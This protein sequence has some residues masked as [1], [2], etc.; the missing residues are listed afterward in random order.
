M[1]HLSIR[2]YNTTVVHNLVNHGIP[3]PLARSLSARGIERYEDI[4]LELKGLIPPNAMMNCEDAGKIL[5]DAIQNNQRIAIVG[6]YDCDG[7]TATA[8]ALIGLKLLGTENTFYLIP[9]R[10]KDGYGLSPTLVQKAKAEGADLLV[11]VDNGISAHVAIKE[12]RKLGLSVLVTDHHLPA[13]TLPEANCIV[14]PN[15]IGDAFPSKNLAGVGV[16]F[17]VLLATRAEM[18]KRGVFDTK[19]QP[20]LLVL[21]DLVALGTIADVVPLDKNN[22][23]LVSKGLE[24]IRSGKMHP[25]IAALLTVSRKN[26]YNL[27]TTDLGFS[28]APRINAAGRLADSQIGVECLKTFDPDIATRHATELDTLNN[29]RRDKEQ[30]G[31]DEA[32]SQMGTIELNEE[33]SIC[34]YRENWH[35]GIVGLIASRIK[36]KSYR[37]T[38]CFA[39]NQNEGNTEELKGSG[40][41]IQGIHLRDLLDYI[42]KRNPGLI[43]KFGG[44]AQAAGLT[45]HKSNLEQFRYELEN[46]VTAFSSQSTFIRSLETDGELTAP[47]FNL[48]LV[49]CIR[50]CV[51]GV[52]FPEPI[53]INRFKV[54]K[55]DLLKGEHL[56]LKLETDGIQL[57]GIWFRRK[58]MLPEVATL[59]YRLKLNE[60][61][62]RRRIDL[63]IE[64]MENE[65]ENWGA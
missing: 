25:G 32:L 38:I 36:D 59:A 56:R 12:A 45:I 13:D 21:I 18:R 9:D 51:W 31:L 43:L 48:H 44:H 40:R 46:A 53:F 50:N 65:Q 17:Y 27:S 10:E 4:E 47:D 14:N 52:G 15:Q 64:A 23:I 57:S 49:Q 19:N 22:R 28:L 30:E 11:T 41:S 54:L 42:D 35:P 62:G 58:E 29:Q 63:Q 6:D 61:N 34:L 5:A 33:K 60:W 2:R 39:S 26:C 7:A 55:Q 24:R 37:P 1:M 20:N 8:T 3:E 16:M